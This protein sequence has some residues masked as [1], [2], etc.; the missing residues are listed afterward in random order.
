MTRKQWRTVVLFLTAFAFG[1]VLLAAC[2]RPGTVTNT[3]S[4]TPVAPACPSGTTVKTSTKDFEQSC[5][6][7]SKGATLTVAQDQ[8]SFHILD[9]GLWN[10]GTQQPET[11]SAAPP[12]NNLQLSGASVTIGPF[13][14]AGTYHIYCTV[15]TNMNLTVIVK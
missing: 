10:N 11:P 5:I 14:S 15:H 6:T 1:S 13:T 12:L 9:Y 4:T 2:V 8:T 3:A 7:L